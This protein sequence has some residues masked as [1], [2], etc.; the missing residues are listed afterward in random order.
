MD[1]SSCY[2]SQ[3][4]QHGRPQEEGDGPLHFVV[5][6]CSLGPG[7]EKV[8]QQ[9]AYR[10]HPAPGRTWADVANP[11]L[12]CKPGSLKGAHLGYEPCHNGCYGRWQDQPT[13]PL[14]RTECNA[15]ECLVNLPGSYQFDWFDGIDVAGDQSKNGNTHT[16]G[17]NDA[18]ERQL[19]QQ[20][21]STARLDWREQYRPNGAQNMPGDDDEGSDAT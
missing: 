15:R 2:Q 21:T 9:R 6:V 8:F 4:G 13:G 14:E 12:G 11:G 18:D 5:L 3:V 20:R 17:V 16:T 1:I 10:F 7:G 19:H